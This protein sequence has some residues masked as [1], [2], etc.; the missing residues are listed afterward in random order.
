MATLQSFFNLTGVITGQ[1][2]PVSISVNPLLTVG[3]P[4]ITTGGITTA[5]STNQEIIAAADADCY[6]Y[7]RNTGTGGSGG[8]TGQIEIYTVS[9]G[10]L[11]GDLKAGDFAF[12]PIKTGTGIKLKYATAVTN[13]EYAIF[14]RP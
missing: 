10:Q 13:V 6:L 14:T 11:F 12:I 5:A 1:S 4:S 2:D 8:G 9:S 7:V 3:D